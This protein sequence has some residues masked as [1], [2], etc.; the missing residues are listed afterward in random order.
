MKI[1]SDPRLLSLGVIHGTPDRTAGNM[2][3]AEN[4]RALFAALAV[5]ERRILR[6][7]TNP[8][9]QIGLR[10]FRRRSQT[11]QNQP[12]Q[13]ADGWVLSGRGYGAAI[14]TRTASR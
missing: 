10:F 9:G 4:T 12:L 11:L 5:P 1:Y 14:L 2:R 3:L 13:E 7:K 6:F 8:F